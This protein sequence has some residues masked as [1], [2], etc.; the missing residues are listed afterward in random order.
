MLPMRTR[1]SLGLAVL[2]V[3]ACGWRAA[4]QQATGTPA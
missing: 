2:A 4:A 1:L 3:V